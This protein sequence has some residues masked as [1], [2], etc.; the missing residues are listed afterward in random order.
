MVSVIVTGWYRCCDSESLASSYR[1]VGND[2][3]FIC[4]YRLGL[5]GHGYGHRA[6]GL[7]RCCMTPA[8]DCHF[9]PVYNMLH[10]NA[11]TR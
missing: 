11:R 9:F 8:H 7:Y 6:T 2:N 4:S 5:H 1:L 3:Q 10:S